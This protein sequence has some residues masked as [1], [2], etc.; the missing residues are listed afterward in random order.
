[1]HQHTTWT[2]SCT[3]LLLACSSSCVVSC[4]ATILHTPGKTSWRFLRHTQGKYPDKYP[5]R[6]TQLAAC[7]LLA[8]SGCLLLAACRVLRACCLLLAAC[9][10]QRTTRNALAACSVQRAANR[11]VQQC[12]PRAACMLLAAGRVRRATYNTQ[13]AR[14]LL[15]ARCWPLSRS[16]CK[17]PGKYPWLSPCYRL[18]RAACRAALQHACN[19]QP[20]AGRVMLAA[21][22]CCPLLACNTHNGVLLRACRQRATRT[23]TTHATCCVLHA[24]CCSPAANAPNAPS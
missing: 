3:L 4:C 12:V 5:W 15:L 6:R 2:R 1:M 9:G 10:V 24:A 13:R 16:P 20:N 8:S 14:C 23:R 19:V 21:C 22:A 11:A 18:K 17:Y 7:C